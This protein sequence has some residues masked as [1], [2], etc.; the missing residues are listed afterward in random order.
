LK[1][2][3]SVIEV[4]TRMTGP[5]A[6]PNPNW[7]ILKVRGEAVAVDLPGG[8]TLFALLRSETSADW[9]GGAMMTGMPGQT[10]DRKNI[11][12]EERHAAM[13]A[14]KGVVTL[15]RTV[16]DGPRAWERV[17]AI[18]ML[19]TFTDPRDPKTVTRVD[20]DALEASFGKGVKLKRITVQVTDDDVTT[21]IE[22]RLGW[23]PRVYEF[24]FGQNFHPAGIPVGD[25]QRLFSTEFK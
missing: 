24:D 22:K 4:K 23:L 11:P 8:K 3:S 19:V 2:G 1:T 14:R 17:P 12:Y 25:F 20:P 6:I 5:H 15:P 16:Q 9:A 10:A 18:P 7:L 13:L 21:G